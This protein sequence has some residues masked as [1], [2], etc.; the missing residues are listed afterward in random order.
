[1][2]ARGPAVCAKAAALTRATPSATAIGEKRRAMVRLV[3]ALPPGAE[4]APLAPLRT[5]P[6]RRAAAGSLASGHFRQ[7]TRRPTPSSRGEDAARA[8]S[9]RDG[10]LRER[11]GARAAGQ[12]HARA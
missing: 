9:G 10:W 8:R 1:M 7:S 12:A 5:P 6:A 11:Q 4:P 2:A 3:M